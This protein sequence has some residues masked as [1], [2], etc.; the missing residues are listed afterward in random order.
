LAS[1]LYWVAA[2]VL[3]GLVIVVHEL[4]HFGAAR[5]T[6]LKVV[7]FAVGFGPKLFGWTGKDG[8][9]YA[10]R[11]LPLGGYCRFYGEDASVADDRDALYR[12]PKWKR[13]VM[14]FAGPAMNLL[15]AVLCL[16]LLLGALGLPAILPKVVAVEPGSPADAA[17]LLPGDV[18]E[19][20][21]GQTV[22]S[23]ED[24]RGAILKGGGAPVA[25][26]L[27]RG[28]ETLDV[29][30]VPAVLDDTGET[31][32]GITFAMENVRE[33]VWRAIKDA[34]VV[35]GQMLAAMLA[36]LK[37]LV[38]RGAG[39]GDMAGPV[40]IVSMVK[41]Q[42]QS[43]GLRAYL[44]MAA[45][46]S[47]NLGLINL[48]PIPGLDGSRLLFLAA[49]GVRGKRVDPNKEG[50]VHLIGLAVLLLLMLPVYFRDIVRLVAG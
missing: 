6:G 49:E 19:A 18:F 5:L 40:G 35:A 37:G 4:G 29:T 12:Q 25:F 15:A 7:S 41:E 39:A 10:V 2:I 46:I 26:T 9:E 13:A 38:T 42:T 47:L 8:V 14:T 23:Y 27:R 44:E 48:L 1:A 32:I 17:G 36:F 20:V 50:L 31:R 30:V 11:L 3:L 28:D 45:M 22:E 21:D 43:G 34:F 16:A 24:V 33:P